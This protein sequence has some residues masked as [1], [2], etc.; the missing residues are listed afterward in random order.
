[1]PIFDD[2]DWQTRLKH[3]VIT[4]QTDVLFL[5]IFHMKNNFIFAKHGGLEIN[6]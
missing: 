2:R 1:L 6:V 5:G 4:D 3:D